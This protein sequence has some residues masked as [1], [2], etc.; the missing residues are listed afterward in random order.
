MSNISSV[1]A[2]IAQEVAKVEATLEAI[3]VLSDKFKI[4]EPVIEAAANAIG[5]GAAA[6]E[7]ISIFNS[8]IDA[9]PAA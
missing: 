7:F 8:I 4:I 6:K 1:S 9:I 5:E 2:N 3:K